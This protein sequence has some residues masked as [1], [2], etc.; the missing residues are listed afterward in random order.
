[1]IQQSVQVTGR[2]PSFLDSSLKID[3]IIDVLEVISK[4]PL[5]LAQINKASKISMPNSIAKYT[6]YC[7]DKGFF[8]TYLVL[9]NGH[10][11]RREKNKTINRYHK[12]YKITDKGRMFLEM[13]Q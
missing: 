6:K 12:H 5:Y 1:M 7:L 2:K 4:Q 11:S 8:S 13:I 10:G 3:G 9:R